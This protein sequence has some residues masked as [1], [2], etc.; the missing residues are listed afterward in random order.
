[1]EIVCATSA[2]VHLAAAAPYVAPLTAHTALCDLC[3]ALMA[4]VLIAA[5]AC[6]A[7]ETVCVVA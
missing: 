5:A 6:A 2:S 3:I 7:V 4:I 1:M